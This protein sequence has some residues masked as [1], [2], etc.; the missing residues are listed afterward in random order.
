MLLGQIDLGPCDLDVLAVQLT[1]AL[2]GPFLLYLTA[3]D[4][5]DT[6]P[7]GGDLLARGWQ[8]LVERVSRR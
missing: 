5:G 1:G 7:H 2:E 3:S 8:D 4:I 6:D